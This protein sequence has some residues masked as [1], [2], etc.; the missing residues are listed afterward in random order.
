MTEQDNTH[1]RT[2][3]DPPARKW[4]QEADMAAERLAA[5]AVIGRLLAYGEVSPA[6]LMTSLELMQCLADH[7]ADPTR[8]VSEIVQLAR[9]MLGGN[10][11]AV[12]QDTAIEYRQSRSANPGEVKLTDTD[13]AVV[14]LSYRVVDNSPMLLTEALQAHLGPKRWTEG[15]A[16]QLQAFKDLLRELDEKDLGDRGNGPSGWGR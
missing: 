1:G 2:D 8:F 9:Q 12:S 5:T 16:E 7:S 15:R 13:Q 6:G 4:P 3:G 14:L 11:Y 10:D